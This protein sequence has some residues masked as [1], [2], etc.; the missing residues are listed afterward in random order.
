MT[1]LEIGIGA[2]LLASVHL[3]AGR[4]RFLH[5]IPRSR[6]LSLASGTSVAYVFVHLLPQLTV[7]QASLEREVGGALDPLDRHAYVLA[8]I[9]LAAFYGLERLARLARKERSPEPALGATPPAVFWIHIASFAIYNVLIGYL[10]AGRESASHEHA[11]FVV[12]LGLHLLVND[13]GLREHH[14]ERYHRVGRWILAMAVVVGAFLGVSVRLPE[15][16]VLSILAFVAGGIVL[17]VLKEELP[18]ERESHFGA[19]A[20][21]VIGFTAI[22]MMG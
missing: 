13:Y 20:A 16:V 3:F 1:L 19:F 9:G 8:V 5:R 6:W 7:A 11:A 10:L 4:L 22:L 15:A 2:L 18:A 17:N 21:G 12:A 14:R